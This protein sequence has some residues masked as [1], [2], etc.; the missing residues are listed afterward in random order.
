M[1]K[2]K[3]RRI[4]VSCKDGTARYVRSGG[5]MDRGSKLGAYVSFLKLTKSRRSALKLDEQD[6]EEFI[7]AIHTAVQM[8]F[9]PQFKIEYCR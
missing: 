9:Y 4:V 7:S 5:L 3:P 8:G 2:Q 6:R 1:G